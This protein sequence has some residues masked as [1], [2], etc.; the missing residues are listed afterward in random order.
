MGSLENQNNKPNIVN[1]KDEAWIHSSA[2]ATSCFLPMVLNAII[3]LSV[4]EII[5]QAPVPGVSA[6]C[7]LKDAVLEGSIP[8]NKAHNMSVYEY[9]Q[10]DPELNE[11]STKQ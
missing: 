9:M 11:G 8:F 3:E 2:I 5:D 7:Y 10:E 4:L 6:T 1:E